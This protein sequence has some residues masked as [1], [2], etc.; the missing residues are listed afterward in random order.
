MLARMMAAV[1]IVA[2]FA[3][4]H[5][6]AAAV[7]FWCLM[8]RLCLW[9]YVFI[10]NNRLGAYLLLL[11]LGLSSIALYQ[12]THPELDLCPIE[13]VVPWAQCGSGEQPQIWG[14]SLSTLAWL[15]IVLLNITHWW[16][17]SWQKK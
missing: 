1:F 7:C 14:H 5:W 15:G 2:S 3:L 8:T 13:P 6:Y 10:S 4:A 16:E 12:A 11:A 17:M 9:V